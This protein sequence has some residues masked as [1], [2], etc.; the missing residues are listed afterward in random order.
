M[1]TGASVQKLCHSQSRQ[2]RGLGQV[3][4]AG[5][6]YFGQRHVKRWAVLGQSIPLPLGSD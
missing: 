4:V 1:P 5:A 6:P 2:I 3:A